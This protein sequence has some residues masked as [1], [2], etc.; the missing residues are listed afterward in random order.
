MGLTQIRRE[1]WSGILMVP[2]HEGG[3]YEW[4]SK[5]AIDSVLGCTP[6][7]SRQKY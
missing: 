1:A 6:W 5:K 3:V 2:K 7:Y 4:D